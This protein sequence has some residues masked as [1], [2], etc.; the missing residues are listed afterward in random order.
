MADTGEGG[1]PGAAGA[2]EA[3]RA[4]LRAV[5]ALP[6]AADRAHA[7]SMLLRE[8]PELHQEL[9][10][11]RQQAVLTMRARGASWAEIGREIG[12]SGQRAGQIARGEV[13][14]PGLSGRGPD[15]QTASD[16]GE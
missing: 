6:D 15:S 16:G 14:R 7:A 13:K 3:V 8:W 11:V 2:A 10:E 1:C 12:T 5:E 9:R 4:A